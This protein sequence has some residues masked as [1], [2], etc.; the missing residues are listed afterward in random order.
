MSRRNV[1]IKRKVI[2][3]SIY[4]SELVSKFINLLMV[5][6]KKSI[7]QNIFYLSLDKMSNQL[8][9]NDKLSLLEKSINNVRPVVEVKSR[10]VGGTTYQIPTEVRPA[11]GS[12]LAIRWIIVGAKKRS[13]KNI[14]FSL[15]NELIDALNGR[16]FAVKRRDDVHRMAESN[17]AFAH[18]RW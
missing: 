12:T 18:Y 9:E 11:R 5:N 7:A 4:N 16:G 13:V 3:D 15:S 2:P 14:V 1:I 6:G 10:R 8:N 17:K